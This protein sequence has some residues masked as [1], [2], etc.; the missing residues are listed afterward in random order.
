MFQSKKRLARYGL[1][2]ALAGLAIHYLFPVYGFLSHREKLPHPPFGWITPPTEYPESQVIDDPRFEASANTALAILASHR[3]QINAPAITAAVAI[4][5]KRVWTGAV[6]WQDVRSGQP[7][8][9]RTQFRIGS[10]SK[11]ITATTLARMLKH[12]LADL[13]QPLS[14][15]YEVLPNSEWSKITPRQL[16]SHT[17][18]LAHY[19][20]TKDW[21]GAYQFMALNQHYEN[22]EDAVNLFNN[23]PLLFQPGND[24]SYSSLGTVLLSAYMQRSGKQP[25]Q[26]L[27][28]ELVLTP[29]LMHDTHWQEPTINLATHYWRSEDPERPHLREWRDVNLSHRLAGGGFISTSSDLVKLGSAYLTDSFLAP[30]VVDTLWQPQRLSNGEINPQ[31]YAIGWRKGELLLEGSPHAS[32]HHGGVSRGAQSWLV[33]IPDY[34]MVIA[35]NINT[36]TTKFSDFA[37]VY[38]ELAQTFIAQSR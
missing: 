14:T 30:D 19:G 6:G 17:A 4:N 11:A 26:Q 22:V 35:V 33:I 24:F 12:G 1:L 15:V 38:K 27:V 31:N 9:H 34:Q 16:A 36:K 28:N 8:T 2:I 5:A 29:L 25:Y 37:S 32:Y 10:T 13:D 7:A 3:Q 21:Q 23:T 18:G 20:Q